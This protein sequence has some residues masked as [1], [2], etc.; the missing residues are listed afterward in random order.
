MCEAILHVAWLQIHGSWMVD[1]ASTQRLSWE[2]KKQNKI[3]F[4]SVSVHT[5][6]RSVALTN[7]HVRAKND[8][9]EVFRAKH[10]CKK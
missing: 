2:L 5:F 7:V 1:E 8:Y 3:E 6:F 10:V 9:I 4:T